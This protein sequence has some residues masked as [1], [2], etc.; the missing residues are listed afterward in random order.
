MLQAFRS[1]RG[2]DRLE[3]ALTITLITFGVVAVAAILLS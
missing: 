1:L 3:F 2:K